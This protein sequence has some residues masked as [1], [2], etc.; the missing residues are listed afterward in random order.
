[1]VHRFSLD[2]RIA[3]EVEQAFAY[4]PE[5][6][7]DNVR[8]KVV[9]GRVRLTGVAGSLYE[10]HR[11]QALA[12]QVPGTVAVDSLLAVESPAPPTDAQLQQVVEAA[13]AAVDPRLEAEV[14]D[15]VAVLRGRVE[16]S[17]LLDPAVDALER[18]P[19]LKALR[20]EVLFTEL[21]SGEAQLATLLEEALR[22]V[23]PAPRSVRVAALGDA[24]VTLAGRVSTSEQRDHILEAIRAVPGVRRVKSQIRL[25]PNKPEG[26]Q[27][28]HGAARAR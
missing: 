12:A 4:D 18:V 19:G 22:A 6:D 13:L 17:K 28:R 9:D 25:R 10:V 16:S 11:A 15:G 7:V 21:V 8:V 24:M 1:M 2:E 5:V 27:G 26:A 3:L 23:S 20:S 14:A